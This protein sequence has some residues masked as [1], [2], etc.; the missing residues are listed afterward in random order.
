MELASGLLRTRERE[1]EREGERE[2]KG[3]RER[4]REGEGESHCSF[5]AL[6]S[7]SIHTIVVHT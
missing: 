6:T 1:G 4:G 2:E 7:Q 3:G 5:T